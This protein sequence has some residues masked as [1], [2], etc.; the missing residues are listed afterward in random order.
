MPRPMTDAERDAFLDEPHVAVLAIPRGA[1]P[2][3]TSP[4]WYHHQPGGNVSFFTGTQGRRSHKASLVEQAGV[5]SLCIQQEA[6]PYR[7]VTIEGTVVQGNRSPSADAVLSIVRRYLPEDQALG[8]AAAE[9]EHPT[10]EFVLF[11][12]QPD[13]WQSL[14]FGQETM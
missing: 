13:R 11:S 7:Y 8:F 10:G 2:P 5:V 6:F 3:H 9:L 12:I 14:D 4:V 1:L